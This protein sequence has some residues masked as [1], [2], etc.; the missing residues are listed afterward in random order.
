V[1]D[2]C[3]KMAV[4]EATFYI[5][6]KEY[7]HLGVTELRRLRQ[8]E[9]ENNRLKRLVADLTLD[10][11]MLSEAL[12]KKSE[13]HTSPQAGALVSHDLL[14]S[15]ACGPVVWRNSAARPGTNE[16]RRA[17]RRRCGSASETLPA[18]ARA[19]GTCASG[20]CC[21]AKAGRSIASACGGCIVWKVCRY[22]CACAGAN[23]WR[24]IAGP[25][26]ALGGGSPYWTIS[27]TGSSVKRHEYIVGVARWPAFHVS[28]WDALTT[29]GGNLLHS[30]ARP[31]RHAH[32]NPSPSQ[33][34]NHLVDAFSTGVR[35]TPACDPMQIVVALIGW[36]LLKR[37]ITPAASN[38][39]LRSAKSDE[40]RE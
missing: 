12:P 14:T 9:D 34:I 5:W 13:A 21:A 2:V 15:P 22:E 3:R 30:P 16:A 35:E 31:V 4:S 8:L 20:C 10:K 23:T 29:L 39:D 26:A 19:L 38:L 17:T 18:R 1:A 6:K 36:S 40:T 24:C 27:A 7:G 28:K 11:H 32:V 33:F 37:R 25:H